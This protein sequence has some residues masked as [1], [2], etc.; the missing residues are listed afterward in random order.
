[1]RR[2]LKVKFEQVNS[3]KKDIL[4][5]IIQKKSEPKSEWGVSF[6]SDN[7][8]FFKIKTNVLQKLA[9]GYSRKLSEEE[10]Y[11]IELRTRSKKGWAYQ[12]AESIKKDLGDEVNLKTLRKISVPNLADQG[13]KKSKGLSD[14]CSPTKDLYLGLSIGHLEGMSGTL[15]GFLE[16]E[17]EEK[18]LLSCNH[19]I[20]LCNQAEIGD[21]IYQPGATD[22]I[23]ERAR[24][25]AVLKN[26]FELRLN[27]A[28][29]FDAG[30][31]QIKNDGNWNVLGNIVPPGFPR[32]G[33]KILPPLQKYPK[34][35][36]QVEKYGRTTGR[37]EGL[38][39]GV[40]ID[41]ILVDIEL[42]DGRKT[43]YRFDNVIEIV[44]NRESSFS[45][46][47]DSGS[48]VILPNNNDLHGLGIVFAGGE[49]ENDNGEFIPVTLC[50]ALKNILHMYRN[51]LVWMN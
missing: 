27:T 34:I 1:M 22:Y 43:T 31:A 38:V 42:P 13:T 41:G 5:S 6:Q 9:V 12:L 19:V 16:N 11:T 25:I 48:L 2:K 3:I 23:P 33:Q 4:N 24:A 36:T 30:Y 49:I 51:E 47:G 39:K 26:F 7:S 44:G 45:D 50:C 40:S 21:L 46:S 32:F 15:G 35:N 14:F 17:D 37:T 20:A 28:N 29:E 18:Y 10:D 8:D